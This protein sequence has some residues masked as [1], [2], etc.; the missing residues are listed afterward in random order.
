MGSDE[1]GNKSSES[2]DG[3]A[4]ESIMEVVQEE[5]LVENDTSMPLISPGHI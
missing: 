3:D 4:K 5:T 1:V 2:T